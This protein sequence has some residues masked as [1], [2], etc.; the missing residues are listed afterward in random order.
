MI[1]IPL[2]SPLVSLLPS[3]P[4]PHFT[5]RTLTR[6]CT[7]FTVRIIPGSSL[8]S[9]SESPP[10]S[11]LVSLSKSHLYHQN[12][13]N[14]KSMS[15]IMHLLG[16]PK[17]SDGEKVCQNPHLAIRFHYQNPLQ[18][19]ISTICNVRMMSERI[20]IVRVPCMV[21]WILVICQGVAGFTLTGVCVKN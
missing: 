11:S 12:H 7:D 3:P 16:C 8:V 13:F 21:R 15:K 18:K 20:A 10:V 4:H 14:V 2:G 1:R 17:D 19:D 6:L 5:V 9:I